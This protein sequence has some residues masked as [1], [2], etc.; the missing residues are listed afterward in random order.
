MSFPSKFTSF[1]RS[2]LAKISMLILD[3]VESISL[4]ELLEARL[5][6]FEDVSEFMLALD[7]LFVLEKIEL[8][9]GKGMIKYV[10]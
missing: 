4:S 10:N 6:K 2:I 3:D 7:V 5:D 8:E 9:E 1:D